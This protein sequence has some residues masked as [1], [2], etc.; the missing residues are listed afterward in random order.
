[1]E[2]YKQYRKARSKADL[3]PNE[4]M[5]SWKPEKKLVVLAKEGDDEK[6][7]HFGDANME[8]YTQH[9]DERRRENYLKRAGG[10]RNSAGQLTKDDKFSANYW[11]MRYLWDY[12]GDRFDEGGQILLAP[13]G[14]PSN[15]T[16]EQY[17]LVRTKAFKD[18]F[19]DWENNPENASKVVDENGEPLVVYHGGVNTINVFDTELIYFSPYK[20]I[21]EDF[22]NYKY[23][24]EGKVFEVFLN[25]KNPKYFESVYS[26]LLEIE[27]H[28]EYDGFIAKYVV[29]N[30]G[31]NEGK[32]FVVFQ[33]N[34]I[35]LA[36]GSNTTF[37]GGN[38][39]IRYAEGGKVN[40]WAICTSSVG[41]E[42]KDKYESCVMQMK[43][44][45]GYKKANGGNIDSFWSWYTS[46]VKGFNGKAMNVFI[47]KPTELHGLPITEDNAVVL[48]LFEKVDQS[49]DAKPYLREITTKADE[50]GVTIY[51]EPTPRYKYFIE[52]KAK[53]EKISKEY[54][55][56]YYE[57][58]GFVSH[59][60]GK[61]MKRE[62]KE[63]AQFDEGG[64]VGTSNNGFYILAN[65]N[66]LNVINSANY[67]SRS[68]TLSYPKA[69]DFI[70]EY[71]GQQ[72]EFYVQPHKWAMTIEESNQILNKITKTA[73]KFGFKTEHSFN[74]NGNGE[75][76]F[77][78]EL[79]SEGENLS[80]IKI[81]KESYSEG[82]E[83]YSSESATFTYLWG[84]LFT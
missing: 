57:K 68:G 72:N 83:V 41:R 29:L 82:G 35:K 51:L 54:L 8:D 21:S 73:S 63:S 26:D 71:L 1:M 69:F 30:D 15:L 74:V 40:P 52:N 34:Q 22:A 33:S 9:H 77:E 49:I 59:D 18:W 14:K 46:W 5:R 50:Y 55:I 80:Y 42:D 84:N 37:D 23:G 44:K 31:S 19:G 25:I 81:Y 62:P 39:D 27:P 3:K 70:Q 43:K 36:D 13:N 61:Y 7:I 45:S 6:V 53:R 28:E 32:Q 79:V 12:K 2:T 17:R 76:I 10:I 65:V 4:P 11:A 24:D 47:S 75:L 78:P 64:K 48:D 38:P 16:P 58:F 60:N 67:L 66:T 56:A 20:F